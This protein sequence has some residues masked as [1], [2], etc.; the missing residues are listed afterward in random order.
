MQAK[1]SATLSR[2]T[3][4]EKHERPA[5][6]DGDHELTYGEPIGL[7]N[8]RAAAPAVVADDPDSF[9]GAAVAAHCS[10]RPASCTVPGACVLV[11]EP[12]QNTT[13]D[14]VGCR[15]VASALQE[16]GVASS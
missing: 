2:Q 8:H 14:K 3:G 5:T 12:P 16:A 11:P 7:M 13:A 1:T 6:I 15:Q 9:G 4:A 10:G